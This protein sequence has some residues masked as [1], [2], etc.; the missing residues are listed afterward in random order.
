MIRYLLNYLDCSRP[1]RG[2]PHYGPKLVRTVYPPSKAYDYVAWTM[3]L[4]VSRNWRGKPD[5]YKHDDLKR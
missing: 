4:G 1:Y 3:S 2:Y 5:A